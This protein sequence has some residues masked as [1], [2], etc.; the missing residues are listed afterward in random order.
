MLN[1]INYIAYSLLGLFV[2]AFLLLA[3]RDLAMLVRRPKGMGTGLSRLWAVARTC[4]AEGWT[5]K[6]WMVIPIWLGVCFLINLRVSTHS[7]DVRER[8]GIYMMTLLRGQEYLLLVLMGM[9]ACFSLP[10]ERERRTIITTGSKP[11]SRLELYLGKVAGFS[12]LAAVFLLAMGVITYGYLF[13]ADTYGSHESQVRYNLM[14]TDFDKGAPGAVP[15]PDGLRLDAERGV[16]QADNSIFAKGGMQVAGAI[17]VRGDKIF[18]F[19]KG[20]STEHLVL[21]FPTLFQGAGM[22]TPGFFFRFEAVPLAPNTTLPSEIRIQVQLFAE[23]NLSNTKSYPIA[24]KAVENNP[25]EYWASWRPPEPF[26]IISDDR[27]YGPIHLDITCLT[28]K[29]MLVVLDGS[30][31]DQHNIFAI[32]SADVP[33]GAQVYPL[34]PAR[35]LGFEKYNLQQFEGPKAKEF[36]P[37]SFQSMSSDELDALASQLEAATWRFR[38]ADISGGR[39][40][41]NKDGTFTLSLYL[42]VDKVD[43]VDWPTSAYVIAYNQLTLQNPVRVPTVV[44]EKRLTEIRLPASLL[45]ADADLFI[46]VRCITPGHWLG[47]ADVSARLPLGETPFVWNLAKAELVILLEVLLLIVVAVMASIRLGGAVAVLLTAFCY[48]FSIFVDSIQKVAEGGLLDMFSPSEQR[49]LSGSFIFHAGSAFYGVLIKITYFVVKLMP[50]FRIFDPLEYITHWRNMPLV[51]LGVI[52][53]WTLLYAIP[54]LAL[55]YLLVRRQELA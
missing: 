43:N 50:D 2:I 30:T 36:A 21:R 35:L 1:A 31:P 4:V 15:P 8:I 40:P 18:K 52:A 49:D 25:G 34:A 5:A 7:D 22:P 42:D 41:L 53:A 9:L 24:L 33:P 51:D 47:A 6:A 32:D 48:F 26:G 14:K 10:R 11:L 55:A 39:V 46:D 13:I 23:R 3:W 16:L 28:D 37:R 20:G 17:E 19:L 54:M 27:Y 12:T 44:A 45:T 38:A 29:I